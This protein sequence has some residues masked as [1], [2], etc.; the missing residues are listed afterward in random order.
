MT[1]TVD[2]GPVDQSALRTGGSSLARLVGAELRR[3][4]SRRMTLITAIVLLVA[5]GLFQLVV[6][7]A[8]SPPSAAALAQQ[9]QSYQQ[10]R[11]EWEHTDHAQAMQ[12]CL[13]QGETQ[14][15]C[16]QETAAPDP[17]DWALTPAAFHEIGGTAILFGAFVSM[18]AAYLVSSSFIGAEYTSG[19]LANWLTF[20][21]QRLRV[22]AAKL[23][24]VVLGSAVTGAVVTFLVLGLAALLTRAHG[25]ALTGGRPGP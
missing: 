5:V 11:Q 16:D 9:Q 18:L 23:I 10:A 20:V 24:T 25:G 6:N 7:S 15:N 12:D 22:Y 14:Q 21:P 13:A 4:T 1:S 19:S 2:A 17:A 3:L 8:V